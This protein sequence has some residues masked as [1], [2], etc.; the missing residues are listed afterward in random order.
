MAEVERDVGIGV[1][2][3]DTRGDMDEFKGLHRELDIRIMHSLHKK[4]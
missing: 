1:D 4:L 2:K 3:L